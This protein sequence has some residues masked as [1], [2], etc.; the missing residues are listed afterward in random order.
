MADVPVPIAVLVAS[1]EPD[2]KVV[3]L[4]GVVQPVEP[5]AAV[6]RIPVQ[7]F[8]SENLVAGVEERDP[9]RERDDGDGDAVEPAPHGEGNVR[10]ASQH[11]AVEQ[12]LVVVS[13]H[14]VDRLARFRGVP[15]VAPHPRGI[16]AR[17]AEPLAVHEAVLLQVSRHR[18][19]D[20]L[21]VLHDPVPLVIRRALVDETV[22][23]KV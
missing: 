16:L 4:A 20:L 7:G 13:A 2:A 19:D 12:G 23:G 1:G 14:V 9:L 5:V 11:D 21:A 15:D 8:G 10:R 17:G 3:R 22:G 18:R 6:V